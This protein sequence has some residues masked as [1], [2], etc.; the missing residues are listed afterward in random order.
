[1]TL[2]LLFV[3]LILSCSLLVLHTES[4]SFALYRVFKIDICSFSFLDDMF[5]LQELFVFCQL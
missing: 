1:M 2:F 4:H 5:N 3:S